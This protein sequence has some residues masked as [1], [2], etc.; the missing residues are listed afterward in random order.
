MEV[1][2]EGV[3]VIHLRVPECN[4]QR[5]LALF[6]TQ[7]MQGHKFFLVIISIIHYSSNVDFV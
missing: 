4:L 6:W 7:P 3:C 2:G 1:S 5:V